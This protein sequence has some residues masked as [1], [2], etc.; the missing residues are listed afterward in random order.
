MIDA[1]SACCYQLFIYLNQSG[2]KKLLCI[3]MATLWLASVNAQ[4][5]EIGLSLDA[6]NYLGDLNGQSTPYLPETQIGFGLFYRNNFSNSFSLRVNAQYGSISGA[7]ANF[8]NRASDANAMSFSSTFFNI[9][10]QVEW[11]FL[12]GPGQGN[13]YYEADGRRVSSEDLDSGNHGTLYRADGTV[14]SGTPTLG[15]RWVP[16]V[17]V[18]IGATFFNPTLVSAT[19]VNTDYSKA[20]LIIPVG[21]GIK[22]Y[23]ND[24]WV[25][26]LEGMIIPSTTDYLDGASRRTDTNDWYASLSLSVGYRL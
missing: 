15:R 14:F 2:M 22:Y 25:L 26:G 7:D 12:G 19:P 4:Q 5:S 20:A 9:G 16:Y 13:V 23:M 3:F 8:P 1:D 21:L 24:K 10:G 6:W 18:G 17:S 11:N